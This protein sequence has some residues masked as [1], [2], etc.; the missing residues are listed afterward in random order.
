MKDSCPDVP[1]LVQDF[2][3][4]KAAFGAT[5]V[6]IYGPECRTVTLWQA[7]IDAAVQTN[8]GLILQIWW[9]FGDQSAWAQSV[10]S[11]KTVLASADYGPMVPFVVHSI[12]F[13]SEPIGDG[14]DG[15]PNNFV[16]D[17]ASFKAAM[18]QYGIPVGISEDWDRPGTMSSSDG[19]TLGSVGQSVLASSDI[20]HAHVMPY[21]HFVNE[22]G[23]WPYV[24]SQLAWYQSNIPSTIPI[25]ITQSLWAWGLSTDHGGGNNDVGPAQYQAYWNS[26]DCNCE[27]FRNNRVGWF[28]HTWNGEGVFDMAPQGDGGPYSIQNWK[29]RKC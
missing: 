10:A 25:M 20:V 26:F 5:M 16:R 4:M 11:L 9:G 1:S 2:N 24:Q 23:S 14:V 29:P 18:N 22:A 7:L 3:T 21:Y 8:M 28:I 19:T 12:S 15:G 13:G 27:T 6:R 17:L